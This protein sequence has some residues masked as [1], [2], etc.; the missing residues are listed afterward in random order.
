[1]ELLYLKIHREKSN[2]L[3]VNTVTNTSMLE[4]EELDEVESFTYLSSI[5]DDTE[6]TEADVIAR[7]NS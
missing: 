6:G 2:V 5:V 3:K 7:N 1:M 4:G